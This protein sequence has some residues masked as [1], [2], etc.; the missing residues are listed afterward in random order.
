MAL[1]QDVLE[2]GVL[3]GS[4]GFLL[5][6]ATALVLIGTDVDHGVLQEHGVLTVQILVKDAL[7]EGSGLGVLHVQILLLAG[8]SQV[9]ASLGKR[10]RVSGS[11]E[12]RHD[13]HALFLGIQLELTELVLGV[14]HTLGVGQVGHIRLQGE[15]AE[16]EVKGVV[17]HMRIEIVH[18]VPGHLGN[19]VL[20]EV[21]RHIAAR[22]VHAQAT[23]FVL[24]VVTYIAL[25]DGIPGL[26]EDLEDGPGRP[27]G[28]GLVAGLDGDVFP[29]VQ[30]VGLLI[31][32]DIAGHK[33]EVTSRG[34]VATLHGNRLAHDV[35]IVVGKAVGH[36]DVLFTQSGVHQDAG[37]V[38]NGK[39][40]GGTEPLLQLGDDLGLLVLRLLGVVQAR[41]LHTHLI[42][43]V[44]VGL[45]LALQPEAHRHSGV[46]NGTDDVAVGVNDLL[47]VSAQIGHSNGLGE[48]LRQCQAGV[49]LVDGNTVQQLLDL[50]KDVD[51]VQILME[52]ELL[53]CA[54]PV[55]GYPDIALV[56]GQVQ[57]HFRSGLRG[58]AGGIHAFPVLAVAGDLH[59]VGSCGGPLDL[60]AVVLQGGTQ[61]HGEGV[62]AGALPHRLQIIVG[63][64]RGVCPVGH[65]D[66]LIG[67]LVSTAHV[68]GINFH[69]VQGQAGIS[70]LLELVNG[71]LHISGSHRGVQSDPIGHRIPFRVLLCGVD[72]G[73][74][75]TVI[76]NLNVVVLHHGLLPLQ[77]D[78]LE[79]LGLTQVD[80]HPAGSACLAGPSGLVALGSGAVDDAVCQLVRTPIGDGRGI[81][82]GCLAQGQVG[83]VL[84]EQLL[85]HF[86]FLAKYT[87]LIDTDAGIASALLIRPHT[88]IAHTLQGLVQG[89][90]QG[91]GIKPLATVDILGVLGILVHIDPVF[92]GVRIHPVGSVCTELNLVRI[93]VG[94]HPH[95]LEA[96][97][98]G[99]VLQIHHQPG[100]ARAHGAGPTGI[101]VIAGTRAIHGIG[102]HQPI[103]L[104]VLGRSGLAQRQVGVFPLGMRLG[105]KAHICHAG[106]HHCA[107]Q[108][109]SRPTTMFFHVLTSQVIRN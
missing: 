99:I 86:A 109:Q 105:Y 35:L 44:V 26:L 102:G 72:R 60:I 101:G 95:H 37:A 14:V 94:L 78:D 8:A 100:L 87:E 85:H 57:G 51:K 64:H 98:G 41:N 24:G 53:D 21:Q 54:V 23:D 88:G 12:L 80:L 36:G 68:R 89:V 106:D 20:Q 47:V 16:G 83:R 33:V 7:N 63:D 81:G 104:V 18:L 3:V 13:L 103:A 22:N 91:V 46:H 10:Q 29:N 48:L 11:V 38:P 30:I 40:T 27:V 71:H 76:G 67:G 96:V 75:G 107:C 65:A 52:G 84:V 82:T 55:Q 43:L 79:L 19:P 5:L 97:N 31:E 45:V 39:V 1:L 25:R 9:G 2:H 61:V 28:A 6:L 74:V 42:E 50:V 70:P 92:I 56:V 73:P 93:G 4:E 34:I 108:H 77:I 32:G 69:L 66:V 58:L 49:I 59:M 17:A 90:G 62:A 15:A